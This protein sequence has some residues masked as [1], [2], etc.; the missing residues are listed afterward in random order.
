MIQRQISTSKK[1]IFL[2]ISWLCFS[3]FIILVLP[4][5]SQHAIEQGLTAS[6]DTNFTFDPATI[7]SI[8][9]NYGV[10]GRQYYLWQRW[11]FDLIWPLVYG[12]PL[13]LTLQQLVSTLGLGKFTWLVYM[14]WVATGLDYLENMLFTVVILN[15]P[16]PTLLLITMGVFVSAL[17]WLAL[18]SAY[19]LLIVFIVWFISRVIQQKFR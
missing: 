15:Y 8:I 3:L 11:T 5:V 2:I 14:P 19:V 1:T 13:Y 4:A 18:M 6:I 9:S 17:K 10:S 7:A 12:L 16:N